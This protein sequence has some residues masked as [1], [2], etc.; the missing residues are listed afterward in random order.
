MSHVPIEEFQVK[1]P[2]MWKYLL[3]ALIA[4]PVLFLLWTVIDLGVLRPEVTETDMETT[5]NK[6]RWL[7]IPLLIVITLFGGKWLIDAHAANGR[8]REWQLKT[9]Q[10]KAQDALAKKTEQS[11]REYVLEV[12]GLGITVEQYRQ[13]KLWHALQEGGPYSSIRESDPQKYPWTGIDKMGQ[14]GGRACDALENGADPSPMFWGVPSMYAGS[15]VE[16]PKDQPSDI[17]PMPGLAGS[18][19]GTGMAWHLFAIGPWQLSERPDQLLEQAFAFF[20][21]HPDLPYLVLLSTESDSSRDYGQLPGKELRVR[22]GHYI[23]EYADASAVFVLARRER[24]EPLRPYAWEDPDNDYLQETLRQMYYRLM[25]TVP[26]PAE[27]KAEWPNITRQPTV[28]EWLPAAAEF[29]KNPVFDRPDSTLID[30]Y[31][32]WANPPPK[33]WK[34]T[35]WFRF[36]RPPLDGFHPP[37]GLHQVRG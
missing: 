12:L 36:R 25:A 23:P 27:L 3:G 16:N 7:G 15:P 18:A 9:Q 17:S 8:E 2:A 28:S 19:E 34:P 24:V 33:D 35:P 29:A 26:M 37:P 13:G 21:A 32:R 20:D 5:M 14:T 22:I 6:L 10:L 11:K 31:K 1:R 4:F 30:A